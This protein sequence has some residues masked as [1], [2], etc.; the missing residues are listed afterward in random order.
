MKTRQVETISY[1]LNQDPKP[2]GSVGW[3]WSGVTHNGQ[4]LSLYYKIGSMFG[5]GDNVEAYDP[6]NILGM[7]TP[8]DDVVVFP[9]SDLTKYFKRA[10]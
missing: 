1:L 2:N 6:K 5:H 8:A 10:E 9:I 3:N 4:V 7:T